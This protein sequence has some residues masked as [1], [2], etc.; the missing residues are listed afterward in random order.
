M[1]CVVR[2]EQR[3]RC[4]PSRNDGNVVAYLVTP[5]EASLWRVEV[6]S[7][8]EWLRVRW[9]EVTPNPGRRQHAYGWVRADGYEIWVPEDRE[10][11]WIEAP[12]ERVAAVAAWVAG[13]RMDL[14]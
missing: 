9:P 13:R 12:A 10:V 8:S 7:L 2:H 6:A 5:V 3:L 4:H 14:C 1:R 11:V